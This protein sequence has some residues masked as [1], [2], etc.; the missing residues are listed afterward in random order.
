[1]SILFRSGASAF[2][3]FRLEAL[4]TR[5][6]ERL[7]GHPAIRVEASFVYALDLEAP[8]DA[9]ALSR[10]DTLLG[11]TGAIAEVPAASV[12]EVPDSSG[13]FFV[14]PRQGT[15]SPWSTKATDILRDH[16][17]E[18]NTISR[19]L[20]EKETMTGEEF[21]ALLRQSDALP[22]GETQA[23]PAPPETKAE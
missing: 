19:W 6:S 11:A 3:P 17:Q 7:P 12:A 20:L 9:E 16:M 14:A 21:M 23:T 15:I 5:L 2:S 13:T 1:M 22:A 10:A 18:L 8:L 4:Q